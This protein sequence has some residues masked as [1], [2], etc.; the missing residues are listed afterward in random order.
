MDLQERLQAHMR[1]ELAKTPVSDLGGVMERGETIRRRRRAVMTAAPVV[2]VLLGAV[3][4]MASGLLS[5]DGPDVDVN[6]MVAAEANLSLSIG[7]LDWQ[8]QPAALAWAEDRELGDGALYVLS[9]APGAKWENFPNGNVPKALY[10]SEDGLDW[11]ATLLGDWRP[12][13]MAVSQGLLYL[14]GTG[15]GAKADT[16]DIELRVSSDGGSSFDKTLE[17]DVGVAAGASLVPK[18]I[19][20]DEGVLAIATSRQFLD[21]LTLLPPDAL[22]GRV[23]PMMIESGVAIFPDDALVDAHE[24]CF[25]ADPSKCEAVIEERATAFFTWE[26]L[27]LPGGS[28]EFGEL[29]EHFTFWSSD[30][31]NFEPVDYPFP[32]GYIDRVAS[33]DGTAVVT[34]TDMG[35]TRILASED[36]LEWRPIAEG[37]DAGYVL[38]IGKTGGEIVM[39]SQDIN[40][41]SLRVYRAPDLDGPWQQVPIDG[42][43][44][45]LVESE[46]NM[47]SLWPGGA[48]VTDSGVAISV[49]AEGA[50]GNARNPI[51][52]I[53]DPIF[54]R[55]QD[56][57]MVEGEVQSQG[58][59]LVSKDLTAWKAVPTSQLGDWIDLAATPDGSILAQGI[60]SAPDGRAIRVQAVATP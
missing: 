50:G 59:L 58:I 1:S 17:L 20:T 21:P 44:Q 43:L 39:A 31:E 45:E 23:Q 30:G 34:I 48:V 7:D 28:I 19:A 5:G 40:G 49:V 25:T 46:G 53:F 60:Q 56:R 22:E 3:G 57:R 18:V 33:V 16:Q 8:V 37:I 12:S 52:K 4:V 29:V 54:R 10:V 27:G 11:T 47:I 2:V 42:L 41:T 9:T 32:G 55:N 51:A 26:E 35:P 6:Q 24:A 13:D 14:V 15:P 38:A 36:A